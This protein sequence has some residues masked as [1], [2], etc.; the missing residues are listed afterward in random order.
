M[1]RT[2]ARIAELQARNVAEAIAEL[3]AHCSACWRSWPSGTLS[4]LA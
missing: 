2:D 3:L 4:A 1:T